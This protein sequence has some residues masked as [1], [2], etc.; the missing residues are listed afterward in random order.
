[1]ERVIL[2]ADC[3]AFYASVECL[4]RPEIRRFPV[5]VGGDVE[6]RHGIILAKNQLA[7][8][9]GIKTGEALWQ[10]KQ[11]CPDIVIVPPNFK[12]Y[13]RFSRLA[14]NI[15][16]DY[17]DR[18]EPFGLDENWLDVTGSIH[19]FGDGVQIAREIQQRIWRELGI[20]VSIGV[21]FN[22]IFAKLGSDY[23][24]PC[25]IT[26]LSRGNYQSKV[27]S[28]PAGDLLMVGR[29][30]ERKLRNRGVNTIGD[31]AEAGIK[32]MGEWLGKYGE[33]LYV[34]AS[35]NDQTP[36]T[37]FDELQVIKLSLIHI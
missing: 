12:L 19:L 27:W 8:Q 11:K 20:T 7:K 33:M 5:A 21:S 31:I 10:A 28:L 37:Q 34:F 9:Y 29:A 18:V 16:L 30:T 2:H 23:Q 32:R 15:Y 26:E 13:Q 36:V 6:Q 14:R 24:K 4:H 1:M 3:D 25:G 17:T 22:K 35:G